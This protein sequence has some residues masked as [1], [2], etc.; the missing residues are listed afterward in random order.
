MG[1]KGTA[2][3]TDAPMAYLDPAN[4]GAK[5]MNSHPSNSLVLKT[6]MDMKITALMCSLLMHL[7]TML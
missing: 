5:F 2:L 7:S 1:G 3:V 6:N 4:E